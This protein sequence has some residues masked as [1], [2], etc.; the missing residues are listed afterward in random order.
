M[1]GDDKKVNDDH[2]V[3]FLN[4]LL[5]CICTLESLLTISKIFVDHFNKNNPIF[6][7]D[8]PDIER[9]NKIK[10]IGITILS[11]L[12]SKFEE[13]MLMDKD[14]KQQCEAFLNF[15]TKT[16]DLDDK[17]TDYRIIRTRID[18]KYKK[19]K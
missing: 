9:I 6:N 5:N 17:D 10:E 13:G 2:L 14:L 7:N 1:N 19:K 16:F 12:V 15:L 3:C 8:V 4:D 11:F 18:C